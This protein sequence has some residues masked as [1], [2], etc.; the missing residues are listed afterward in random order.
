MLKQQFP[1]G[2]IITKLRGFALENFPTQNTFQ[3]EGN[4]ANNLGEVGGCQVNNSN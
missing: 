1:A 2:G 4:V 3:I